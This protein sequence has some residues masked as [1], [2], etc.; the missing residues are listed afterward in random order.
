MQQNIRFIRKDGR[1]IPIRLDSS[2]SIKDNA[3]DN[4]HVGKAAAAEAKDI[5]QARV[6]EKTQVIAKRFFG[7]ASGVVGLGGGYAGAK[8]L[9]DKAHEAAT[10]Y[11]SHAD[12]R[13]AQFGLGA[14]GGGIISGI[15]LKRG[16]IAITAGGIASVA[17]GAYGYM[18]A[19]QH[20]KKAALAV[21]ITSG[22][23]SLLAGNLD[24]KL[25]K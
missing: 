20:Q 14:I 11:K 3:R 12:T 22:A 18:Q 8:F 6:P 24:I 1:I 2:K 16:S 15:G 7:V 4:A 23:K 9:T 25:N 10:E 5:Y 17:V 21:K 19:R 13:A